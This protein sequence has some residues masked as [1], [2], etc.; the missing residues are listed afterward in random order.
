MYL[1]F[2]FVFHHPLYSI[3]FALFSSPS[4]SLE[5]T[6]VPGP[7]GRLFSPLST[8]ARAF[9]FYC[10]KTPATCSLANS[11]WIM[12]ASCRSRGCTTIHRELPGTTAGGG[13]LNKSCKCRGN[14]R[15]LMP[16]NI[17]RRHFDTSVY[18]Q[19]H[20]PQAT[21]IFCSFRFCFSASG[22]AVVTCVVSS[23]RPVHAFILIALRFQHSQHSS[24]SI[25]VLLTRALA[26]TAI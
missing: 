7:L 19:S 26:P 3:V 9:I 13:Y 8:T 2:V 20:P 5:V 6:Q 1:V 24:I 10:E 16:P 12:W 23:P 18:T 17:Y 14:A 15:F 21:F 25:Q 22:Q 11:H 4:P